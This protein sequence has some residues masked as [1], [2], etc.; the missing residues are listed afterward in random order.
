MQVLVAGLCC[1]FSHA[2][3]VFNCEMRCSRIP[4][5]AP[6]QVTTRC[7]A[8]YA[9]LL[10]KDATG[11]AARTAP[12]TLPILDHRFA[13]SNRTP[14]HLDRIHIYATSGQMRN[15]IIAAA[16]VGCLLSSADAFTG[17]FSLSTPSFRTCAVSCSPSLRTQM[18][19]EVR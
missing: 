1:G 17:G 13:C 18:V 10:H 7:R 19:A 6:G 4:S 2:F 16:A 3:R 11:S 12:S 5:L 8:T 14:T 15:P 9:E